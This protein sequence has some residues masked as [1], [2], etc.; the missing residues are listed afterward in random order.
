M[1]RQIFATFCT[2]LAALP[3]WAEIPDAARTAQ[4]VYLG[5]VHDNPAHHLT[6][7]AWTRAL[8]PAAVVFEMIEPGV[9]A[10]L[11]EDVVTD[12]AALAD[13]LDWAA[14]GWPE[15][16]MY[17]PIFAALDGAVILGGAVPRAQARAVFSEGPGAIFSASD[18]A[19][20]GLD[21]P[22]PE[23][24]QTAREAMQFAAHCD[25]MPTE[26]MGGMVAIQRVRDAMLAAQILTALRDT[27]GPVLVI[28]GNGH[29]RRD[30]G[31]PAAVAL[32]DPAVTQFALGQG[33]DG[34][35]PQGTFDHILNAPAAERDDPCAAFD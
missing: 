4:V 2:A 5:E 28:T 19:R 34:A 27:G 12:K 29:A 14:S 25:A 9:A 3:V 33:E 10:R 16:D 15:F 26:M 6:Q 32:A 22:L 11:P 1:I 23:D 21:T 24:Q 20:F 17:W 30:W 35:P 18:V 8:S 7:A 31:A 13:A